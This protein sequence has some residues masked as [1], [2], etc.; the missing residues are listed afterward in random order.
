MF[1]EFEIEGSPPLPPFFGLKL[2]LLQHIPSPIATKTFWLV[3]GDVLFGQSCKII[4]CP[5]V[6]SII[7]LVKFKAVD[8]SAAFISP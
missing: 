3:G 4:R 8:I 1:L 7:K 5:D 2:K 6:L